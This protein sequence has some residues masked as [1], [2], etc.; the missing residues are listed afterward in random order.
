MTDSTLSSEEP[1]RVC[2]TCRESKPATA[3]HRNGPGKRHPKRAQCRAATRRSRAGCA[4]SPEAMRRS[5]LKRLYGIT[6]D[7]YDSLLEAQ[8]GVCAMCSMAPGGKRPP[9]HVDHC[10]ESGRV[11]A[12]LCIGC[13]LNLGVFEAVQRRAAEYL[14]KYGEGHPLLR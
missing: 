10:H 13:N 2:V 4:R 1:D 11:R 5:K 9:L 7:V 6:P 14:T 3:F 12:L 8:G